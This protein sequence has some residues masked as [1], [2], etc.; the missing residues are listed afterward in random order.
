M[1]ERRRSGVWTKRHGDVRNLGDLYILVRDRRSEFLPP[2]ERTDYGTRFWPEGRWCSRKPMPGTARLRGGRIPS[3]VD[4]SQIVPTALNEVLLSHISIPASATLDDSCTALY[5][6]LARPFS[7]MPQ[8]R[9]SYGADY[10]AAPLKSSIRI[11]PSRVGPAASSNFRMPRRQHVTLLM[12]LGISAFIG[13]SLLIMSRSHSS[14]YTSYIIPASKEDI[15]VENEIL[16]GTA[17]APKLE[18]A[19]LKYVCQTC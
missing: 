3:R 10:A 19:T 4:Y 16:L 9:R 11:R 5:T 14:S 15:P 1:E 18:N 17:T 2:L 6:L 7:L 8:P 13:F 12:L